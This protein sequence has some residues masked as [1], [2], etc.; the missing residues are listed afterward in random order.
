[1]KIIKGDKIKVLI[2][3]DKGREA[4]VIRVI[5][6]TNRIVAK[7]LNMFKKHVKPQ[8]GQAG[9]IIEKERPLYAS[10]VAVICSNCKKATRV[11]Y[12]IDESGHKS[13]VC[14]KCH[15]VL[16]SSATK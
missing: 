11:A 5:P 2:G 10:K 4:E 9:A 12:K 8:Q 3:K 14:A 7:G 16:S 13:R 15:S 1:M 6:K